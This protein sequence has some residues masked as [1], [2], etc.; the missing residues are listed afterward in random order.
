M[1]VWIEFSRNNHAVCRQVRQR[2]QISERPCII[3]EE[4][5]TVRA[6]TRSP[7]TVPRSINFRTG[8]LLLVKHYQQTVQAARTPTPARLASKWAASELCALSAVRTRLGHDVIERQ[9][10]ERTTSIAVGRIN[11]AVMFNMTCVFR[12]SSNSLEITVKIVTSI[13]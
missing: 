11:V 1:V 5:R 4:D 6:S 7:T 10:D 3:Y 13:D 8:D 12:S 2:S 9:A